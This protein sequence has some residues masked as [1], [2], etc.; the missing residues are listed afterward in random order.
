MPYWSKQCKVPTVL[1]YGTKEHKKTVQRLYRRC[2]KLIKE[3]RPKMTWYLWDI[4]GF[5]L[6][7][8][9]ERSYKIKDPGELNQMCQELCYAVNA[10]EPMDPIFYPWD[11]PQSNSWQRFRYYTKEANQYKNDHIMDRDEEERKTSEYFTKQ[12]CK[13]WQARYMQILREESLHCRDYATWMMTKKRLEEELQ[14]K[15]EEVMSSM[16][17][18]LFDYYMDY[19]YNEIPQFSDGW[20]P[21]S[22]LD[23]AF[24]DH[25][26][27]EM[28]KY[29][30]QLTEED[31]EAVKTYD[32]DGY[33]NY[34]N[35]RTHHRMLPL[36]KERENPKTVE[37][38]ERIEKLR[39]KKLLENQNKDEQQGIES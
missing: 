25:W 8:E 9:F 10:W 21:D 35:S 11:G 26:D 23:I 29:M 2:L 7:K 20:V 24:E 19:P 28:W 32:P 14:V 39:Q 30:A 6:R 27:E 18:S 16:D 3:K 1:R 31:I 36:P 15:Y 5:Y 4:Q 37:R 38:R 12:E 34:Y 13:K 17:K 22:N 33:E